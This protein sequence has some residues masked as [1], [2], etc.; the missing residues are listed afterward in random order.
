MDLEFAL[1]C[2]MMSTSKIFN[3]G[4]DLD[5]REITSIVR[6]AFNEGIRINLPMVLRWCSVNDIVILFFQTFKMAGPEQIVVKSLTNAEIITY[7]QYK[8][9]SAMGEDS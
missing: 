2:I 5:E 3:V 9:T 8:A 7:E 1:Q 4:A 6:A